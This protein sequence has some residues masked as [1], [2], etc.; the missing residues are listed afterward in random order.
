ML[1]V[2]R[3][4]YV[5]KMYKKSLENE[6]YA[7]LEKILT[8][9][10][11]F[12]K[13]ISPVDDAGLEKMSEVLDDAKGYNEGDIK[14]RLINRNYMTNLR[15]AFITGKR[16]VGIAAINITNLSLRQKS[17][18]YLDPSKVA[19]LSKKERGFVKDLSIILPHNTVDVNGRK[20]VS[21][22]GTMTEDGNQ[23]ISQRL[24]GYATAFVDI[25]NKP[26]ITK[27]V[28]SDVV[29]STFMFLESIGAGNTGI[30]F[31]NQPIIDKYLE[32]LDSK[33]SKNVMNSDDLEYIKSLFPTTEQQLKTTEISVD[34]LLK[35]IEE[36]GQKQKFD[37]KKNAEQ[38][39]ILDEFVKYKI[40]AD[41]LFAYTQA[42]NYDTTRFSSSDTYLKKEWGTMNAANYNLISNVNDV[43]KNTFIGRLSELLSDSYQALGAVMITENPKIKAYT[44]STLKRYATKK[45][46]PLSDYE[47][48]SNLI[49]NSFIDFVIQNNTA[50]REMIVPFLVDSET[51]IVNKLEQAKQ[52]YPS[53]QLLQDLT[54]VPSDREQGAKT[55]TLKANIKDAYSENLY[56]GMMRELRDSKNA[57][58]Q[59][60]YN[61]IINVSILQGTSQSAISIR[62]I[63]P[64]EDYAQ[65][66]APIFQQLQADDQLKSFENAMFER[67][68]FRNSDV[69]QE[70]KPVVFK[71]FVD[72]NTGDYR[73]ENFMFD[74]ITG[75]DKLIHVFPNYSVEGFGAARTVVK[76]DDKYNSYQLTSDFIKI[77]K[78]VSDADGKKFNVATGTEINKTDYAHML[79]KGDFSLY[80]AYYYKKVYTKSKD[81][82]GNFIPLSKLNDKGDREYFYKLIN[83]YGDG[84]KAVEMNT[85]FTPSVIDNGSMRIPNEVSDEQIVSMIN[86]GSEKQIVPLPIKET[87]LEP[88]MPSKPAITSETTVTQPK[89]STSVKPIIDTSREW[90]GDLESRPVYTAEGVNTMRSSATNAFENFGNPFSEAG[91]AGTIKVASIGEAVVAYKE[92]LLGTN[93]QDVKPQQ[94]EWILDQINQGKLDEATLL[95]A[96]KLEARGQGMHPTAL[97]EVVEELRGTQS[98]TSVEN[99][100]EA[101][102]E[103]LFTTKINQFTYSYNPSTQ[104]VIHNSKTGDKIETNETQIGK[105]LAEY[106]KANNLLTQSFNNQDYSKVGDRVVNVNNGSI[107]TQK[108]I[109]DLF[110]EETNLPPMEEQ[111]D[112]P[113]IFESRNVQIDYTQ[114][115]TK[116]LT[117]IANLID[118]GGDGYYLLAGYA[119]TGK[120]TIAENIAKY[121]TQSGKAISVLAP[122]NKAAKVLNDKLKSTGVTS[123]ATTIHSAIY[124]EP[125][126]DTGEWV[127][128]S[129]IKNSVIIVDESS[130]IAKEVM[131][132]LL[133][134]TKG[135]NNTII[136]MG[137][138]FQLEPVGEDS[139]LFKEKVT[140][141][142]NSKSELTEVKR[143]SLDSDIL[144]V[145]TVIRNDKV[146]YVPETSTK[147]FKITNSKNE[148]IQNF[149]QSVKNNDDVAMI[150]ATNAERIFMNKLARGAKFGE[151]VENIINPNET[152][153]SIANSSEYSNSELFNVK[154]LRGEPTKHSITFTD[155]YGKES[156]Y[157]IYLAY[158]VNDNNKEIPILLLPT[159][160]KPSVYHAQILKAARESSSGLY[161]ALSGWI[162]TTN[163]G[164]EKLS[165]ALT[166]GTY[167]YAITAHKSQGSQWD[168]VYVNQNYVIPG[169]DAARWFYTAVTRAAKEVEVFPTRAN[170]IIKNSEIDAKLSNIVTE[171]L[172]SL[173]DGNQYSPEQI[174]STMLEQ[175]GYSPEEIG[176]I[177]KSI[178]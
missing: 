36:Y 52:K 6:Y 9:P 169:S 99:V 139:G 154:N 163:R 34:G 108:Q 4:A 103:N 148:F 1:A 45:Y 158:V 89:P 42:L 132:D 64:V 145:A 151:N 156:R 23:L 76:L 48:V 170:T 13:L 72:R 174:N 134:L 146:A 173:K 82:F 127:A 55:I 177:L 30:Y 109:L 140:E 147:D 152:I 141:V 175:M 18:V 39:L 21:L 61:D 101:K 10:E 105:V 102:E 77:P 75:E 49:K 68:N 28:K 115:Q 80:D 110:Q 59:E 17:K 27:I 85:N 3:D 92:W 43:L 114:G 12:N 133:R 87:P 135:K 116:A 128:K 155:N 95:Y 11:N 63:I 73:Q 15:H 125:D 91:Y 160:D 164:A 88:G 44:L 159:I 86:P 150:V 40:L 168:K 118:K 38:H 67:N 176:R 81:E 22:S 137:D 153:I 178:C 70:F 104:E 119:G 83:V 124:G 131:E 93:H 136:F 47:K 25:A 33:S 24:S 32:Y 149:K 60:L 121:G 56:T 65:K 51:S 157:D 100:E 26:F 62:N 161:N 123:E 129:D 7:S 130:M 107:V 74:P 35:N 122:T 79:K 58:L 78:V 50:I 37:Q 143:Q 138:S 171:N 126:P 90:R 162:F 172:I 97:A 112:K 94:R 20:Y 2:S 96:G 16:W 54:P 66:I 166:I 41:Q 71:P 5:K 57:D 98:S 31:L 144:K 117:D 19:L 113:S 106:A 120:T 142:N 165:P 167:G 53:N 14:A 84:N 111:V 29:V 46:M 69:F 8:L